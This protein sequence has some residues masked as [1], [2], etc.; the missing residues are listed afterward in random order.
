MCTL[1]GPGLESHS[2]SVFWPLH[3]RRPPGWGAD[4]AVSEIMMNRLGGRDLQV[5]SAENQTRR[6]GIL[7]NWPPPT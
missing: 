5:E 4:R 7:A 1:P 6:P 3:W 2:P